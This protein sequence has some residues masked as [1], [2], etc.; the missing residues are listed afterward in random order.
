MPLLLTEADVRAVVTMA[1]LIAAME[2]ALKAFSAGSV[3]Q[4]VRTVLEVG[5]HRS[6]LGCVR[7]KPGAR[8]REDSCNSRF[9]GS[10]AQPFRGSGAC[11]AIRRSPRL[12]SDSRKS[13]SV[14]ERNRRSCDGVG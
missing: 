9:R 1:D 12:E 5:A 11:P 7:E 3:V 6:C 2:K 14:C 10:G 13:P 8:R 4:P